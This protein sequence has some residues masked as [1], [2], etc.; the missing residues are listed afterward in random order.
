MTFANPAPGD[1][2]KQIASDSGHSDERDRI[3]RIQPFNDISFFRVEKVSDMNGQTL[4]RPRTRRWHPAFGSPSR[5]PR[6]IMDAPTPHNFSAIPSPPGGP[7]SASR[8]R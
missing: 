6:W 7:P 8:V 1:Q 3:A 4:I 5:W 2:L